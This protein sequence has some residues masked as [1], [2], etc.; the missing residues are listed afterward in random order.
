MT[1]TESGKENH[2]I[3]RPFADGY[4]WFLERGVFF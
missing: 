2:E 3:L 1:S 4:G